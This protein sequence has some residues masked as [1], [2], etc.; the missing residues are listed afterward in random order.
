MQTVAVQTQMIEPPGCAADVKM[1][2][3]SD[4]C[5]LQRRPVYLFVKEEAI[6]HG[7]VLGDK[8]ACH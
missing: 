3:H 2:G 8:V 5:G 6:K 7:W 1:D 4:E